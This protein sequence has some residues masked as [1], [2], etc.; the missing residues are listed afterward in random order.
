ME[1]QD[2]CRL[3]EY[4]LHSHCSKKTTT[5]PVLGAA[6]GVC[7][8]VGQNKNDTVVQFKNRLHPSI[9]DKISILNI[10]AGVAELTPERSNC[11]SSNEKNWEILLLITTPQY[12][13]DEVYEEMSSELPTN[14]E[15][16]LLGCLILCTYAVT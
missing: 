4:T 13:S 5:A 16:L 8:D 9:P 14:E 7:D 6:A 3:I 12:K 10:V 11:H 2:T 1:I 15:K